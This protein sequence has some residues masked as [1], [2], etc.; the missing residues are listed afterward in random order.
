MKDQPMVVTDPKQ[1]P[2]IDGTP[3]EVLPLSLTR[4]EWTIIFNVMV[5][6]MYNIGDALL[7]KPIV[8]KLDPLVLKPSKEN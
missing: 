4:S 1:I 2:V 7:V 6:Q 8:D 5:R 3:T